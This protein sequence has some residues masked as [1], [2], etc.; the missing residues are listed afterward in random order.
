MT[1]KHNKKLNHTK[2]ESFFIKA[3]KRSLNYELSLLKNLRIHSIFYTNLLKSADPSTFIQK[4]FYYK[5]SE[6]EYIV[7][8][9]LKK[10]ELFD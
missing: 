9:I 1:K 10:S 8:K 6:E 5:N 2:I 7:K 3:V 4:E